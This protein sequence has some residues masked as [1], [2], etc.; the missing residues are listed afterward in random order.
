MVDTP[1]VARFPTAKVTNG[2]WGDAA[3]LSNVVTR[4]FEISMTHR[5]FADYWDSHTK[6]T[7]P[8]GSHIQRM[9]EEN[10]RD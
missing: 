4:S 1:Q 3:G 5:D 9:T 6:F 10:D 8:I 2:L 7:S